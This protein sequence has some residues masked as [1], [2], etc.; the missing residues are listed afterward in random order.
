MARALDS[1]ID[2][3]KIREREQVLR[4]YAHDAAV[5]TEAWSKS[6]F[7]QTISPAAVQNETHKF[8]QIYLDNPASAAR[9]LDRF[10]AVIRCE[11][12]ACGPHVNRCRHIAG[13]RIKG[14][15]HPVVLHR[16]E[17]RVI[18]HVCLNRSLEIKRRRLYPEVIPLPVGAY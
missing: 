15:R 2:S 14:S 17:G 1:P 18:C 11:C 3:R 7:E 12:V 13:A 16:V 10:R 4:T 8:E 5:V 9:V 6:T